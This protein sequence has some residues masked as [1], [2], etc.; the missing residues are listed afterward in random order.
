MKTIFYD[1]DNTLALFSIK[2]EEGESLEKMFE[3]GFFRNLPVLENAVIALKVLVKAG[4]DVRILSACVDSPYCKAEKTEWL[5]EH[6][7]FIPKEKIHLMEVGQNKAEVMKAQGV[8]VTG[9][10]LVDDYS[11][12]LTQWAEYGGIPVKKRFSNKN[13][14]ENVVRNHL[15]IFEILF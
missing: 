12:N 14:W 9:T 3:K 8:P 2:G 15:D 10:Y 5:E 4:F 13:G 11:K 6:F 7:P 1:M